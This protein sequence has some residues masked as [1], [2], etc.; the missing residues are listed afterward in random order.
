[1][2]TNGTATRALGYLRVS[3]DE[4]ANSGAGLDAQAAA[5]SS[6]ISA[7][8]WELVSLFSDEG[9]SA[10]VE[11]DKRPALAIALVMLRRGEADALVV[12]KL[13]RL[14]RSVSAIGPLVKRAEREGWK[15]VILDADVD[16]STAGGMLVAN[17]LGSV[18]EWE[19]AVIAERTR[20]AL[21][22]R[23]AK[24]MRLGRPVILAS[25]VRSRVAELREAGLSMQAVADTLNSDRTPTA[26]GGTW[27]PSTVR[28][29]LV[30]LS[31]DAEALALTA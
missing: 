21:A 1:M 3:T 17:V 6:T 5:I 31:L 11:V 30:S 28:G 7:R 18:A 9:V 12:S 27:H 23:K 8:G 16:M 19:R 13:D 15:L 22:T 20:A 29:V 10:G 25:S 2:D 24:G 14:T 26:R 4:Q